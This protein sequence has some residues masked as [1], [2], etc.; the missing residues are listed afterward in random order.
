MII[1]PLA[2]FPSAVLNAI[3]L[4]LGGAGPLLISWGIVTSLSEH[5]DLLVS[6]VVTL[7][8]VA[9]TI[10]AF[11]FRD[12]KSKVDKTRSLV[13]EHSVRLATLSERSKNGNHAIEELARQV[14]FHVRDQRVWEEWAAERL[15]A[16][17]PH[18]GDKLEFPPL[19]AK[20]SDSQEIKK[21]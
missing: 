11:W 4:A 17:A 3:S 1:P 8:G 12:W 15:Y 6:L 13:A 19:R 9:A 2:L 16:L 7:F 10:L 18:L 21:G 14:E 20:P 5:A